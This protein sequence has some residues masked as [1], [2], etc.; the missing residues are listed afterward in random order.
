M[1][2]HSNSTPTVPIHGRTI[3]VFDSG[4][5]GLTVLRA[6]LPRLPAAHYVYLG[7]TARLPYGAKSQATIARY[8]VES[9]RFLAA[10]GCEFLV[11][12]CNTATALALD[13]IRAAVPIPVLGVIE[14]GAHAAQAALTS[15]SS[16]QPPSPQPSPPPLSTLSSRPQ[17]K[18][19][20]AAPASTLSSRPESKQPSAA[21]AST[22][23][24][25]P[26]SKQ[27][28]AAP[29]STLSSRP[30]SKQPSA[31]PA[32]TLSS[33]PE[34]RFCAAVE[35]PA[36]PAA[37]PQVLVLATTATVDSHAYRTA[38]DALGL[39][40]TEFACPLLVPLVE[41]GWTQNQ[42]GHPV[43]RDVL[44]IY[45]SDALQL[46]S[47]DVVLLGCTHYPLLA[48]AIENMLREL[49]S[50]AIVIDS[51]EATAAAVAAALMPSIT[52]TGALAP[53]TFEC[54]ATD[55]VEK[56]QRLGSLFLQQPIPQVHHLDLGG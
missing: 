7:D 37:E 33:R 44:R 23:S 5:G 19:P 20:S 56:F 34:A 16:R 18:Q 14:P 22:L 55:S 45:L 39:R 42:P 41:E 9:A 4:F 46:C 6:L 27:L 10:R 49:G 48:S 25:R 13:D 53:A 21:P 31:A 51:A 43:T 36:A 3:G 30:E 47:P 15:G 50:Q 32:S 17:S 2:A 52:T 11:I 40:A 35:R 1:P 28:S 12:A 26:E 29:A 54:F 8:A 38:C 24:S